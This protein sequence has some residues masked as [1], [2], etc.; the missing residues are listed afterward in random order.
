MAG[1]RCNQ[2]DARLRHLGVFFEM[3]KRAE[4]RPVGG[5]FGDR[6]LA[7]PFMRARVCSNATPAN[8]RTGTMMSAWA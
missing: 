5:L 2:Q 3:Q 1:Q 7:A 6:Y 8:A 4:R